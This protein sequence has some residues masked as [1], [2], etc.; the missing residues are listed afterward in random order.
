[1]TATL[2]RVRTVQRLDSHSNPSSSTGESRSAKNLS[3]EVRCSTLVIITSRFELRASQTFI[4][5]FS[6]MIKNLVDMWI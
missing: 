5:G 2:L 6:Y 1:M 4:Y 3:E